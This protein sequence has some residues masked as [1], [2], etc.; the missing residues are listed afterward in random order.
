LDTTHLNSIEFI[1]AQCQRRKCCDG[2]IKG[3]SEIRN[4]SSHFHLVPQ[5][6]FLKTREG[7]MFRQAL[8]SLAIMIFTTTVMASDLRPTENLYIKYGGQKG[9]QKLV[10]EAVAA[11]AGDPTFAPYFAVIG[12]SGQYSLDR[13]KSCLDLQLTVIMGGPGR[14]PGVSHFRKAPPKG[15]VCQSLRAAHADL[16]ITNQVFDQ[17]IMVIG[18]VLQKAGVE[19]SDIRSM[20][21]AILGM[22]SE[23]VTRN[24]LP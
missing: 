18:S 24:T 19:R 6:R 21:P 22:R 14:Y 15:Y 12:H 8:L 23:V 3:S 20:A 7:F 2:L 16:A 13:L 17:F 1:S 5:V 9:V 4:N 11:L 10:D